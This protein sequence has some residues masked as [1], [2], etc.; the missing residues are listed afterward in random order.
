MAEPRGRESSRLP[1]A[2]RIQKLL[3]NAPVRR[4][5][6][7]VT[8]FSGGEI[9]TPVSIPGLMRLNRARP[10]AEEFVTQGGREGRGASPEEVPQP[11][12]LLHK[13]GLLD[14]GI[15]AEDATGPEGSQPEQ[16][17][18]VHDVVVDDPAVGEWQPRQ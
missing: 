14:G 6:D 1:G 12:P 15:E 10:I 3:G 11:R 18:G 4:S 13:L 2:F 7:A 9:T 17:H 16:E 8:V 5:G